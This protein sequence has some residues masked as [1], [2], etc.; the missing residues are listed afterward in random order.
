MKQIEE[1][2]VAERGCET[3]RFCLVHVHATCKTE[4]TILNREGYE[5]APSAHSGVRVD[6]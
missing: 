5:V 4:E 6:A 3:D 1:E 2:L